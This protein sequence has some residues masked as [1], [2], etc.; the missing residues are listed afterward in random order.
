MRNVASLNLSV[1]NLPSVC[2]E[3][4]NDENI[5]EFKQSALQKALVEL[6]SADKGRND[7]LLQ[8][9][10]MEQKSKKAYLKLYERVG[11]EIGKDMKLSVKQREAII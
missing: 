5:R 10:D 3:N 8:I 1:A 11:E 2:V 6:R 4:L 7:L 9:E